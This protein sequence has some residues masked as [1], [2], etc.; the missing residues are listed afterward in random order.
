MVKICEVDGCGR[1]VYGIGSRGS[2]ESIT[3][4]CRTHYRR[5]KATGTTD[6]TRSAKGP[7][8]ERFWLKVR[9]GGNCW[10]WI[11]AKTSKGYG[12]ITAE[13]TEFSVRG[14]ILLAHRVCYEISTGDILTSSDVF[15]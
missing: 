14:K 5:L 12:V 6:G 7:L 1:A 4:Y 8:Q 10:E 13:Q 11:G 2:D 9:K 15:P 3:R